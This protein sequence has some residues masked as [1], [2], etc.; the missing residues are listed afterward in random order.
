MGL[1]MGL[2]TSPLQSSALRDL[3][4]SS[5]GA[6]A[7]TFQTMRYVGSIAGTALL[8]AML[9][10][11][12][13]ADDFTVLFLVLTG[14]AVVGALSAFGLEDRRMVPAAPATWPAPVGG[15]H[16]PPVPATDPTRTP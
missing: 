13:G 14:I 7:G 5:V 15:D 6:G 8:A 12:P 9:S 2:L 10:A 16:E 3:D 11:S 1:G 4:A